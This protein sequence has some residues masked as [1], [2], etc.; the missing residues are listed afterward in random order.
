[1]TKSLTPSHIIFKNKKKKKKKIQKILKEARG[2]KHYTYREAKIKNYR[3]SPVVQW[4]GI[5]LPM[6]GTRI[7][8]LVWEDSPCCETTKPRHQNY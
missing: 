3:T 1:M 8:S 6:Q 2:R 4:I 5:C 7:Q